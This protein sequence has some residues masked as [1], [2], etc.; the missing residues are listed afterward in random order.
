M[1]KEKKGAMEMALGT[2]VTVILLV[3]V[4]ALG[5]VFIKKIYDEGIALTDILNEQVY[6]EIEKIF[7]ESDALIVIFPRTNTISI[8]RGTSDEGFAFALDNLKSEDTEFHWK[9]FVDPDFDIENSNCRITSAE[10]EKWILQKEGKTFLQRNSDSS[11]NP[12]LILFTVP[13]NAPICVIS[14]V[15]EVYSSDKKY[16]ESP[17]KIQIKK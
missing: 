14:Y 8:K 17:V 15:V 13:R 2:V 7:A 12:E 5:L 6:S 16:V 9:V 4:L 1:R 10:A 3:S 11:Q